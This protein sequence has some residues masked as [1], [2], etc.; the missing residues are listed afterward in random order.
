MRKPDT[1]PNFI[2]WHISGTAGTIQFESSAVPGTGLTCEHLSYSWR[3]APLQCV[4]KPAPDGSHAGDRAIV[5]TKLIAAPLNPR[6]KP[7][8]LACIPRHPRPVLCFSEPALAH[9]PERVRADCPSL[10]WTHTHPRSCPKWTQP[11]RRRS[12]RLTAAQLAH[13][14]GD[15]PDVAGAV[16]ARTADPGGLQGAGAYPLRDPIAEGAHGKNTAACIEGHGS[17]RLPSL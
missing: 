14:A 4:A 8:G 1:L 5:Q 10:R 17:R 2:T 12:W 7:A 3:Y 16:R 6:L 15:D 11:S 9:F 13:S